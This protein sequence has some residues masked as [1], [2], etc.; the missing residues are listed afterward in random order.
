MCLKVQ[1]LQSLA[2]N[3]ILA[4]DASD[5]V[6]E[7]LDND[8]FKILRHA[9]GHA[10]TPLIVPPGS[11]ESWAFVQSL[12]PWANNVTGVSQQASQAQKPAGVTA[13]VALEHLA[14]EQT[15]RFAIFSKN[16]EQ[17]HVDTAWQQIDL[18]EEIQKEGG[19]AVAR[20]SS[21]LK[22]GKRALRELNFT[23]V[24]MDRD[25]YELQVWPT[26]ILPKTPAGRMQ[27]VDDWE[28]RGFID[29]TEARMLLDFPDLDKSGNVSQSS[30]N[31]I[32]ESLDRIL[33]DGK[34]SPPD[35][36]MSFD[37]AI[38]LGLQAYLDAKVDGADPNT[39]KMLRRWVVDARALKKKAMPPP[40]PP[41]APPGAPPMGMPGG[42][43]PGGGPP[44]GAPP[45]G[46]PMPPP[47]AA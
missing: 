24:K 12:L 32:Q 30:F 27:T 14:D 45:P 19:K 11:P 2:G 29:K 20:V 4:D 21:R 15:G 42:L 7:H 25:A 37:M 22:S 10:P 28:A 33:D 18:A 16:W 3:W 13:A 5:I 43:P 39:L 35:P 40:P 6:T 34:Y 8:P 26:S 47:M 41:A 36:F 9:P 17:Y 31:A 46:A 23:E 38:A 1:E 44:M